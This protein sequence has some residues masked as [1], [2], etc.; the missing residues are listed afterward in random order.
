[1]GWG[2]GGDPCL[3][4]GLACIDGNTIWLEIVANNLIGELPNS[5][6]TLSQLRAIILS[7]ND[8]LFGT[9]SNS[10]VTLSSL[11]GVGL[12]KTKVSGSIPAW[13]TSD[14]IRVIALFSTKLSGTL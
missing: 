10:L 8:G 14:L 12:A 7:A 3:W 6:S 9:I 2:N 11:Q 13:Q 1:M 4:K 5:L